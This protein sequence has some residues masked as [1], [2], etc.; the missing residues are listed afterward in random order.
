MNEWTDWRDV[1]ETQ[2]RYADACDG[3][4]WSL[5]ER[6]F[7]ADAT[8]DFGTFRPQGVAGFAEMIAGHLSGCGPTQHLLGNHVVELTGDQAR[9]RSAIRAFHAGREGTSAEG[10]TYTVIG[11]YHDELVRT[12]NG[13]RIL[14]RR[15]VVDHQLGDPAAMFGVAG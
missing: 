12:P 14:H 3:K 11:T 2:I 15:M 9:A 7:T 5:F 4:D 8:G 13:W 1:V 10:L 6:V